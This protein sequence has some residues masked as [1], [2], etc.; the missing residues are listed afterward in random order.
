MAPRGRLASLLYLLYHLFL[1]HCA[2]AF[3]VFSTAA[4]GLF[5]PL[6][7]HRAG[8]SSHTGEKPLYHFSVMLRFHILHARSL[9]LNHTS[10]LTSSFLCVLYPHAN[11]STLRT[12]H[13]AYSVPPLPLPLPPPPFHADRCSAALCARDVAVIFPGIRYGPPC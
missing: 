5:T 10:S 8:L 11:Y 12:A 3:A 6:P 1:T 4:S 13:A 7:A 2:T 9:F